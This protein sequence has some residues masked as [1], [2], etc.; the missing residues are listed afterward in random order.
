MSRHGSQILIHENYYNMAFL[1]A[2]RVLVLCSD[3]GF[4]VAAEIVTMRGQGRD[5]SLIEAK[6]FHVVTENCSVATG[7]H[8]V[9]SRHSFGQE[10][11]VSCHDIIFLC[12]DGVGQARSFMS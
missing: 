4:L 7:F 1:V 9:V 2:T 6:E 12:R 5:R 3:R 8:G 10:Q 11:R